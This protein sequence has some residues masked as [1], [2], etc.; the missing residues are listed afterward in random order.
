LCADRAGARAAAEELKQ[1]IELRIRLRKA[2]AGGDG[3][4]GKITVK[5]RVIRIL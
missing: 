2:G 1:R 5:R 4:G 3:D